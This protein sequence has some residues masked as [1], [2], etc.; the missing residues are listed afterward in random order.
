MKEGIFMEKL[1]LTKKQGFTK[2]LEIKEVQENKDLVALLNRELDNLEKKRVSN[3]VNATTIEIENLVLEALKELNSPST[4]TQLLEV[5]KLANYTYTEGDQ[6][7]KLTNQKVN[8]VLQGL[9]KNKGLVVN[10]KDKKKS[11]YA[12]KD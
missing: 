5:S 11:F 12:L 9:V 1:K 10:T 8:S 3:K 6:V 7:K 4:V 2:L